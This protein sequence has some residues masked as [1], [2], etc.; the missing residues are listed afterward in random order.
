MA[1]LVKKGNTVEVEDIDMKIAVGQ[2]KWAFSV[3]FLRPFSLVE[4]N[5]ISPRVQLKCL[6]PKDETCPSPD[7]FSLEEMKG[8]AFSENCCCPENTDKVR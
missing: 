1:K 4:D 6:F 2:I 8:S 7:S 5:I 3:I